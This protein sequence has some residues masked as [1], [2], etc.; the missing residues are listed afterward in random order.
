MHV[1]AHIFLSLYLLLVPFGTAGWLQRSLES[2]NGDYAKFPMDCNKLPGQDFHLGTLGGVLYT[3]IGRVPRVLQCRDAGVP[4]V[5]RQWGR[6]DGAL[7]GELRR[8]RVARV[9]TIF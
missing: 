3:R 9:R 6:R 7:H 4:F 2:R 1:G 5:R 8:A